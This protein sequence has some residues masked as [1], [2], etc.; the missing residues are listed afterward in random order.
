MSSGLVVN[1]QKDLGLIAGCFME[2]VGAPPK[3]V[4]GQTDC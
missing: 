4:T 2:T 1:K 3:A